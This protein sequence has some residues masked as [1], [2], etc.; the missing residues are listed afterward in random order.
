[1]GHYKSDLQPE[2]YIHMTNGGN[3]ETFY[4]ELPSKQIHRK[5]ENFSIIF[6]KNFQLHDRQISP[7]LFDINVKNFLGIIR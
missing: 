5:E 2:Q 3:N 6:H 7:I 1:M 4:I